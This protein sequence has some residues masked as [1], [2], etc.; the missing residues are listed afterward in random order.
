MGRRCGHFFEIAVDYPRHETFRRS[1]H[2]I[3]QHGVNTGLASEVL[4]A[5]PGRPLGDRHEEFVGRRDTCL[6]EFVPLV[7]L[8]GV[9]VERC[10]LVE[11][12]HNGRCLQAYLSVARLPIGAAGL[13]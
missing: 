7:P 4:L 9:P 8:S 11:A 12:D 5:E 3:V 6:F 2:E 1:P 13:R 10:R